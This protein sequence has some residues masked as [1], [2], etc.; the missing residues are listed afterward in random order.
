MCSI[1]NLRTQFGSLTLICITR[2]E[3]D[4]VVS[5]SESQ[6]SSGMASPFRILIQSN[7]YLP[8]HVTSQTLRQQVTRDPNVLRKSL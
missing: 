2:S 3:T 8:G 6:A 7:D 1:E 5:E 4:V